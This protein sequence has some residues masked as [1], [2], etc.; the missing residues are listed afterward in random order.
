MSQQGTEGVSAFLS[1]ASLTHSCNEGEMSDVSS[2]PLTPA[3]ATGII[4]VL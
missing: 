4:Q 1:K 2:T 3:K